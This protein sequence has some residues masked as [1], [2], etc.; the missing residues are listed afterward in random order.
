ML[1]AAATGGVLQRPLQQ[2]PGSAPCTTTMALSTGS[3]TS[4]SPSVFLFVASG[5]NLFDSFDNL[6][7][8][9]PKAKRFLK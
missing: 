5:I 1:A 2:S 6:I 4:L 7:I 9:L 8:Y 3:P